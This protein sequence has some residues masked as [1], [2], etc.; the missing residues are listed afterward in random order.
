MSGPERIHLVRLDAQDYLV[1][2]VHPFFAVGITEAQL[3][4]VLADHDIDISEYEQQP[5]MQC[6]GG[7]RIVF[8]RK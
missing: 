6:R 2:V 1:S 8:K 5:I 7:E 4:A 3:P